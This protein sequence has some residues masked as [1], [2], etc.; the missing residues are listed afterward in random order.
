MSFLN[1]LWKN[2]RDH[3]SS[4]SGDHQVGSNAG[5]KSTASSSSTSK[6]PHAASSSIEQ[7]G[8]ADFAQHANTRSSNNTSSGQ[9]SHHR[10]SSTLNFRM[11]KSDRNDR[12]QNHYDIENIAPPSKRQTS[13]DDTA[14][15]TDDSGFELD[16]SSEE[17]QLPPGILSDLSKHPTVSRHLS[18]SRSGRYKHR[19]KM[20][21]NLFDVVKRDD[22]PEDHDD[23]VKADSSSKLQRD[24]QKSCDATTPPSPPSST[25]HRRDNNH[26]PRPQQD[27]D[28]DPYT[29]A[30][31]SRSE[32]RCRKGGTSADVEVHAV[33][34]ADQAAYHNQHNHNNGG[35]SGMKQKHH[36]SGMMMMRHENNELNDTIRG[37]GRESSSNNRQQQQTSASI[38]SSRYNRSHHDHHHERTLPIPIQTPRIPSSA[39]SVVTGHAAAGVYPRHAS[40]DQD[41]NS[42]NGVTIASSGHHHRDLRSSNS[43]VIDAIPVRHA[44]S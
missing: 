37:G 36:G 23:H 27:H 5:K 9:P 4:G 28:I 8:Y 7:A 31:I 42:R 25:R 16:T 33:D 39:S 19:N 34:A 35:S 41:N 26:R 3:K 12:N 6:S 29:D 10:K 38:S 20:R 14:G 15:L 30:G 22:E 32:R 17:F 1:K 13:K 44:C 24:S 11:R 2:L 43:R 40:H 21:S 18:V